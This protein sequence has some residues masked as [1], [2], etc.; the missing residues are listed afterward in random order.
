MNDTG[1]STTN[2]AGAS[3]NVV[4]MGEVGPYEYTV[5]AAL[6]SDPAG[7]ALFAWLNANGF[8][9]PPSSKPIV[10][11]Y[12][13]LKHRFVTLKLQKGKSSGEL[14]P[15]ECKHTSKGRTIWKRSIM[16]SS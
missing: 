8:D 15:V 12:V 7:D 10:A 11:R 9:Q 1:F 13:G 2:A 14:V 16:F 5:I 6:A 4:A 3:V